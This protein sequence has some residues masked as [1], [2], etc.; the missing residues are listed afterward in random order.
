MEKAAFL[1]KFIVNFAKEGTA[2]TLWIPSF[3]PLK[4]GIFR[5]EEHDRIA[6]RNF[7]RIPGSGLVSG[8]RVAGG[9]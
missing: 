1:T 2:K 3:S 6:L 9:G 4:C 5:L 7:V 8:G